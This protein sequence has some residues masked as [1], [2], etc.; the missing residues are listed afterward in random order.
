MAF[1]ILGISIIVWLGCLGCWIMTP[2]KM[3]KSN[4]NVGLSILG[5]ICPLW[6]FIWGWM[7]A[8]KMNHKQ[9]MLIWS[10]LIGAS[11]ILNIIAAAVSSSIS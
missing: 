2:I 5:C 8:A 7:N 10:G 6:A 3:F 11:I 1:L 4:E 9:I